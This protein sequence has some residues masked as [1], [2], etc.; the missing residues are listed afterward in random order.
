MPSQIAR[1]GTGPHHRRLAATRAG[2]ADGT[3][4]ID[5]G[6]RGNF[7]PRISGAARGADERRPPR[8]ALA[9]K[10]EPRAVRA[11]RP[12]ASWPISRLTVDRQTRRRATRRASPPIRV[13]GNSKVEFRW[14]DQFGL[15]GQQ[16]FTLS[17]TGREDEAP[18][19]SCEGLPRQK[20][21]LDSE[22]A[23]LQG[24]CPGRFR[25]QRRGDRMAGRRSNPIVKPDRPRANA[26]W[27][28]AATTKRTSR[29][30]ARSPPSR[31]A[32]SRR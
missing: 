13:Q 29:S 17:I 7:A 4:R 21:V 32:S 28:P 8:R 25:R 18:T 9:R 16:P 6:H 22:T 3:P 5:V 2:R 12:A 1:G 10:W 24:S 27:R 26:F 15:T 14:Q 19:L 31:W 23:H 11:R 30:P 20:V